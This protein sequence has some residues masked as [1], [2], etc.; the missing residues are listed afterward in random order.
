MPLLS[1]FQVYLFIVLSKL[2][3]QHGTQ[4][5]SPGIKSR[6]LFPLSQPGVLL[7]FLK[8][9]Y[10]SFF[11]GASERARGAGR[12]SQAGPMLSTQP[13]ER[14]EPMTPGS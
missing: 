4:T 11:R 1:L 3:I 2:Y 13:D 8:V 14:L 9:V 12:E 6:M 10:F 7:L 5:P